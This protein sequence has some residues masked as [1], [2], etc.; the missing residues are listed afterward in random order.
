MIPQASVNL[1]LESEGLDQPGDWPGEDSGITIGRGYDLGQV[2]NSEFVHDWSPN[3][4]PVNL[5]MLLAAVGKRGTA[6]RDIARHFAGIE[7]AREDAD[8][9]FQRV[10]LPEEES[11]MGSIFPGANYL[12]DLARGALVS[13]TYN[14]GG[15]MADSPTDPDHDRRREMRAI[16]D[17]IRAWS[18]LSPDFRSANLAQILATIASQLRSM[19]R[20]WIGHGE[21]GL[22][23]RRDAEAAMVESAIPAERAQPVTTP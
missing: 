2:S 23:T 7:I 15:E 18:D 9:V 19:K 6:A 22:L 1:I 8:A 17:A 13:L 10:T 3:L 16:R 5:G 4:A 12:P 14:R 11:R 21:N 20:L